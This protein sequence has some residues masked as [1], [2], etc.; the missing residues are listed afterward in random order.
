MK[1]AKAIT[2]LTILY[3]YLIITLENKLYIVNIL[4]ASHNFCR[5]L[6]LSAYVLRQ[7]LLQNN[8]HRGQTAREQSDQGQYCLLP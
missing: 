3:I 6:L 4:Y 2:Y 1:L 5:L 8:M 7:L